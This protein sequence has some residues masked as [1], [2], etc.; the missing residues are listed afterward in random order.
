MTRLRTTLALLVLAA[1]LWAAHS[2]DSAA[3]EPRQRPLTIE[4]VRHLQFGRVGATAGGQVTVDSATGRRRW[5][6]AVHDLGGPAGP[7][8]FI[9]SGEPGRAFRLILPADRLVSGKTGTQ[10][11][12]G[13]FESTPSASGVIGPDGRAV[14]TLGATLELGAAQTADTYA[15]TIALEVRYLPDGDVGRRP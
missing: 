11:F 1:G 3:T 12:L 15:A 10:A 7:A 9:V 13:R 5:S 4:I 6:G 14:I 2:A 8:T